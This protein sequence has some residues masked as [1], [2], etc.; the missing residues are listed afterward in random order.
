M[1]EG[2]KHLR[3][4]IWSYRPYLISKIILKVL[5]DPR[6]KNTL[7]FLTIKLQ[8]HLLC[9]RQLKHW[10][11]AVPFSKQGNDSNLRKVKESSFVN[12]PL[13]PRKRK[14]KL[15][16]KRSPRRKRK[17]RKRRRKKPKRKPRKRPRK[18]PLRKKL[19][20]NLPRKRPKKSPPKKKK[21]K[22][23]LEKKKKKK[24]KKKS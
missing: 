1:G 11:I 12:Q 17:P 21:K 18:S 5:L 14:R 4:L 10:S 13:S 23:P 9:V 15:S 20:K 19:R 3:I 6:L 8:T 7:K 24:K 22:T 16:R 2:K